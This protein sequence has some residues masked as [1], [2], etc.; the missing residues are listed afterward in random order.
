MFSEFGS[1]F[2]GMNQPLGDVLP[3]R[4][5]PDRLH[6]VGTHV[7]VL[8]VVSMLPDVDAKEGNESC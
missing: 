1:R 2:L 8:Q 5:L 4:D 7:L 3:V 6:I